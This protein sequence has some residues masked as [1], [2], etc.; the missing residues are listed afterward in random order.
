MS[1]GIRT[2]PSG[3]VCTQCGG[4]QRDCPSCGPLEY[5]IRDMANRMLAFSERLSEMQGSWERK[6]RALE[7]EVTSLRRRVRALEDAH[8]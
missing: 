5:V 3:H 2:T 7:G 1:D 4:T 6:A 8:A